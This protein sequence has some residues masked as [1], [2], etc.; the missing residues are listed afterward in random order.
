M[1]SNYYC[2]IHDNNSLYFNTLDTCINQIYH[3]LLQ[4][5]SSNSKANMTYNTRKMWYDVD[6]SVHVMLSDIQGE[7]VQCV[8]ADKYIVSVRKCPIDRIN[9]CLHL[10]TERS[11]FF[12]ADLYPSF[13]CYDNLL[14]KMCQIKKEKVLLKVQSTSRPSTMDRPERITRLSYPRKNTTTTNCSGFNSTR[15]IGGHNCELNTK[16]FTEEDYSPVP[17]TEVNMVNNVPDFLSKFTADKK[18]FFAFT[19]DIEAGK[20]TEDNVPDFFVPTYE[21]LKI[22]SVQNS[23]THGTDNIMNEFKIYNDLKKMLEESD[24]D[25]DSDSESTPEGAAKEITTEYSDVFSRGYDHHL[26]A[27]DQE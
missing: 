27:R 10:A 25:T 13:S 11:S 4:S 21:I 17:V 22:M 8:L 3:L 23:L 19:K 16:K 12:A 9:Y 26:D 18:T 14:T 2:V 5:S 20:R 15:S 24:S 6:V 7:N 1:V